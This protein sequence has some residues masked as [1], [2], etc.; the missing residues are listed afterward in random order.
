[1]AVLETV[2]AVVLVPAVRDPVLAAVFVACSFAVGGAVGHAIGAHPT[3][4][5]TLAIEF[6][7]RNVAVA[8]TI[9]VTVLGRTDFAIFGTAY[10]LTEAPLMA[11][12]VVVLR[13][14]ATDG[15]ATQAIG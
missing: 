8:T 9:A 6:A 2:A 3:D 7:T 14:P 11:A 15:R 13:R 5:L 12:A 10:F 1:M 4:R